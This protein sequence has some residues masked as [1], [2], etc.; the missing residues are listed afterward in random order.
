ML[1]L[2]DFHAQP[3][4]RPSGPAIPASGPS[5]LS[6]GLL[7]PPKCSGAPRVG[8]KV[9]DQGHGMDQTLGC[10]TE[11][12]GVSRR[13]N[14]NRPPA[15]SPPTFHRDLITDVLTFPPPKVS[16][17]DLP[18]RNIWRLCLRYNPAWESLVLALSLDDRGLIT[19]SATYPSFGRRD[20]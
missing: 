14:Q 11:W 2:T 19:A 13:Q 18:G 20:A 12:H 5:K 16:L 1:N 15:P 9:E 3:R 4:P 10:C 7:A 6:E 17:K 8:A